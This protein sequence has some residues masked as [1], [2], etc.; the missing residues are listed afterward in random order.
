MD[1]VTKQSLKIYQLAQENMRFK[2]SIAA[3][4]KRLM[5]FCDSIEEEQEFRYTGWYVLLKQ[6]GDMWISLG[7]FNPDLS[8]DTSI[9]DL[10]E[11][12]LEWDMCLPIPTKDSL[13]E[14]TGW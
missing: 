8:S 5:T 4:R 6:K 9:S 12:E 3:F 13:K 14:F 1:R 11:S 10:D 7:V 2:K